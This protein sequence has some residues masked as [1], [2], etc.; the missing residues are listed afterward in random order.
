MSSQ[1][2][3]R[4]SPALYYCDP[5]FILASPKATPK[6]LNDLQSLAY[7][8]IR[9]V[10]KVRTELQ[11]FPL[12]CHRINVS[13]KNANLLNLLKSSKEESIRR[14]QSAVPFGSE[15]ECRAQRAYSDSQVPVEVKG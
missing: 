10:P 2:E 11:N 9:R 14:C 5:E 4:F 6:I 8:S 7:K 13:P 1:I 3:G 12:N 15:G